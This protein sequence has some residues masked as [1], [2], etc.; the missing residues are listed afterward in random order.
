MG[1]GTVFAG[2]VVRVC[3]RG[4]LIQGLEDW[5]SSGSGPEAGLETLQASCLGH[6]MLVW[7][8]EPL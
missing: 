5:I 2:L 3:D 8:R 1:N 6:W 7:G 4:Q